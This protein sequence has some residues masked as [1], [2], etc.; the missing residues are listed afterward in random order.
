MAV[1]LAAVLH[2]LAAAGPLDIVRVAPARHSEMYFE[3]GGPA[4]RRSVYVSTAGVRRSPLRMLTSAVRPDLPRRLGWFNLRGERSLVADQV[5]D[6][7]DVVWCLG[8]AAS[9]LAPA[10]RGRLLVVD[11]IDYTVP[12]D[13]ALLRDGVR[14]VRGWRRRLKLIDVWRRERMLTRL[15]AAADLTVVSSEEDAA[16]AP[17]RV[18]VVRNSYPD[19]GPLVP[20]PPATDAPVFVLPGQLAYV[21]NVDGAQ[22]LVQSIW[23]LVRARLPD[24]RLRLVGTPGP[25][26]RA[27][28]THPGVEVVGPV[29]STRDE[30][31]AA[32]ALVVPLRYGSG[33][34]VKIL[35]GWAHGTPVVS[36]TVGAAGLGAVHGGDLLLADADEGFADALV[37]LATDPALGERLRAAGRAHYERD[38][39]TQQVAA[40]VARLVAGLATGE[41]PTLAP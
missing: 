26:V 23:P 3:T 7:Y 6:Q 9:L 34:R 15:I 5:P 14:P 30:I 33:T 18:A 36:T 16:A 39:T 40:D 10:V 2:G 24:A 27:L 29:L 19:P 41:T 32:T 12:M 13:R 35:E 4:V 22:W 20:P 11:L 28:A 38:Y 1:R 25:E 37:A 21:P 31:R 17:G 8:E